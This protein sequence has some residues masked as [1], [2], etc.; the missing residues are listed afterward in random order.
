MI[1]IFKYEM[2]RRLNMILTLGGLMTALSIG[3]ILLILVTGMPINNAISG[4]TI[5]WWYLIT[6]FA[7]IFIPMVMFFM[8]S[9]GHVDELL[10]KDTN[11]L[12]LTIPIRSEEILGGRLLA[13]FAEYCIYSVISVIFFI[14]FAALQVTSAE[15]GSYMSVGFGFAFLGI[16]ENIFVYN[17]LPTLYFLLLIISGFLLVGTVFMC[18]KA[19]TRSFIR[20]KNLAQF[21]AIIL[22]IMIMSQISKLGSYLSRQWNL[23][24]YLDLSL[25]FNFAANDGSMFSQPIP[26]YLVTTIM[27]FLLAGGFFVAASWL[28]REKVEL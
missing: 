22:F 10:Y 15:S 27:T 13:G 16:L 5:F 20:K 23:V 6:F 7:I 26:V 8:C 9:N 12:M 19:L 14:I 1:R 28:I 2:R 4:S 24:Q 3:S 18:V 25:H 21:I 11:Y 17:F